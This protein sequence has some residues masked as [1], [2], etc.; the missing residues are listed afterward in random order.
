M[1]DSYTLDPP[2]LAGRITITMKSGFALDWAWLRYFV[3]FARYVTWR[4]C[5]PV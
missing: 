5:V 2:P 1:V 3:L 4:T